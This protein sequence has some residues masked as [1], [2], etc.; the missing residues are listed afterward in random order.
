MSHKHIWKCSQAPGYYKCKKCGDMKFFN[1][2]NQSY[3]E[4][5]KK[6]ESK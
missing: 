1:Y 3:I 6:E 2:R 5:K 4:F